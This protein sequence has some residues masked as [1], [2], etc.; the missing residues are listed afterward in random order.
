MRKRKNWMERSKKNIVLC[1]MLLMALML[2]GGCGSKTEEVLSET[3]SVLESGTET[4]TE[5]AAESTDQPA[6]VPVQEA[7]SIRVYGSVKEIGD[8]KIFIEND[9]ANDM[10]QQIVLNISGET[11]ILDAVDA[12]ERAAEDIEVGEVIYA[13]VSPAMTRSIP[14]ISNA[15]LILCD[16][17]ADF[18]VPEY[19]EIVTVTE[20]ADGRISLLTNRDMIYWIGAGAET[21]ILDFSTGEKTD[22]SS[23][24]EGSKVLAWY[25]IVLQSFPGQTTP[26]KI[27]V[28]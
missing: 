18:G 24:Q 21:E 2:M 28:F 7:S 8:G 19:A 5:T 12:Q 3:E 17:P 27:I 6:S 20:E 13:Y 26:H 4:E 9:N 11:K 25:Q 10:Y 1:S 22:A 23:I 14:P 15:E 16:I